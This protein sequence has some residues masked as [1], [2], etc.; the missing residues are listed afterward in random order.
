MSRLNKT[1]SKQLTE[2]LASLTEEVVLYEGLA[3]TAVQKQQAIIENNVQLLAKFTSMEQTFV[4]KGNFLTSKRLDLTSKMGD[5]QKKKIMSLSTFISI[6]NLSGNERWTVTEKQLK[7]VLTKIKR[8]NEENSILLKTSINFVQDLIKIYYP[9]DKTDT[10]IYTKDG[11][12][13]TKK[14]TVVDY[15]V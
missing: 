11:K 3:D 9:I 1:G 6:N 4:R 15:G 7:K 13:E 12:T 14:S 5:G 2:I 8:L 10:K